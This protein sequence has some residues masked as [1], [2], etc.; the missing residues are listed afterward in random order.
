MKWAVEFMRVYK[1]ISMG[2]K[3]GRWKS[4]IFY[5]CRKCNKNCRIFF[6]LLVFRNIWVFL[7][8]KYMKVECRARDN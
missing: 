6:R 4:E 7:Y 1:G 5:F 2:Q 3:D 8:N